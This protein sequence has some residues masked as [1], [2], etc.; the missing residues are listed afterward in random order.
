MNKVIFILFIGFFLIL[1]GCHRN[2]EILTQPVDSINYT[3][4]KSYEVTLDQW[5]TRYSYY[6][7]NQDG[8]LIRIIHNNN[9]R[10]VGETTFQY[11]KNGRLTEEKNNVAWGYN[12]T[13]KYDDEGKL[14]YQWGGE[15]H[16]I[17]Y[18]SI[19]R[20]MK[21]QYLGGFPDY[22]VYHE[23][24]YRYDSIDIW[25]IN[26]EIST[27]AHSH[28]VYYDLKYYYN[29]KDQL[30]EK[31]LVD[32]VSWFAPGPWEQFEYN[33]DGKLSRKIKYERNLTFFVGIVEEI[34]YFY[35]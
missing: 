32:G 20:V 24:V 19:G 10:E 16:K 25:K 34:K 7:Y 11:D 23:V 27:D 22:P 5:S 13:F 3:I 35:F 18:D 31:S 17:I 28:E 21:L 9:G 2:E 8:R 15:S 6:Y 30:Y 33:P 14:I 29:D 26:E 4:T 12:Y 1:T